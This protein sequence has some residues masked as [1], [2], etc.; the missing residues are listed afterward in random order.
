VLEPWREV[1]SFDEDAKFYQDYGHEN[2]RFAVRSGVK[3]ECA[4]KIVAESVPQIDAAREQISQ[5]EAF[6]YHKE[7]E[8]AMRAAY[9]AAAASARVPLYVRLVDPFTAD[10]ALWEFENLFVLSG[11]TKGD[12]QNV[13]THFLDLKGV[14]P[15][16]TGARAI[17]DDARNFVN[18]CASWQPSI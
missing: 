16:E 9:E 5:A 14:E 18:Y 1:P 2:E 8:H 6:L 17:L 15:S 7:Y 13:S 3:G 4:D 10:E 11:Q 12:W